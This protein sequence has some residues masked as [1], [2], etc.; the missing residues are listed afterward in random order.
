MTAPSVLEVSAAD[1]PTEQRSWLDAAWARVDET[2]LRTLAAEMTS[3]ASPTGEERA[4][5]EFLAGRLG[6]AGLDARYQPIDERQGNAIGRLEG[7]G[8]G[9]DLLLYAPIDTLTAGDADEDV[10]WIGPELRPDMRAEATF[11]GNWVVG[12]GAANPKGHGACLVAAAEAVAQAGVPLRGSVLVGLGAGGMPT[13]RRDGWDGRWNAGQGNG[14]SFL[15]E[16]GTQADFALIAKPGWSVDWE[17]VGL[18]WFRVRVRGLYGYVGA[19][20]RIPYRNP[21]VH[22]ATVVQELEAWFPEY[23]ERNTSGL[24]AP[25]G[26]VGHIRGGWERTASLSPAA[27]DLLVDLRVSPRTPPIEVRRQFGAQIEAIRGRHPEIDLDWD[28]V[29]A[30]PGTSTPPGTWIV[31]STARAWEAVEERPYEP[32][33]GFTSGATDANI[34]RNRG[35]PTARIGMP[36]LASPDGREVDFALG[37]NAVDVANMARLTRAVVYAIVDTCGRTR[38]DIGLDG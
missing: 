35:I 38:R 24:V 15:L 14:C 27:C 19:R 37:M 10:P 29:L 22:A 36:K 28:M 23:A 25:Q 7:A 2:V 8:D 13:N 3:I 12:L 6:R 34:L 17:E 20:H 31:Q 26:Q 30:I 5:A 21:I 4:L 18:C 33:P 1:L 9:P 11:D 16:Q 32:P